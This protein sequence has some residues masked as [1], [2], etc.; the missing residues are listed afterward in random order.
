MVHCASMSLGVHDMVT[1]DHII[2]TGSF[3]KISEQ[4]KDTI[5]RLIDEGRGLD[6]VDLESF[7]RWVQTSYEALEF[8]PSQQQRFEKYCRFFL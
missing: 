7:N 1:L 3:L 2:A 8:N 5:I 6:S 4:V